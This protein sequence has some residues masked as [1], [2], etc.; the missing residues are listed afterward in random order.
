[1]RAGAQT[2]N[3]ERSL[4]HLLEVGVFL[5]W[6]QVALPFAGERDVA[7]AAVK[8]A[9]RAAHVLA[10]NRADRQEDRHAFPALTGDPKKVTSHGLVILPEYLWPDASVRPIAPSAFVRPPAIYGQSYRRPSGRCAGLRG[11]SQPCAR[12]PKDPKTL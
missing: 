1:M 4:V 12:W 2:A 9:M 3:G 7:P 11:S 8:S 10:V 6:P 5:V